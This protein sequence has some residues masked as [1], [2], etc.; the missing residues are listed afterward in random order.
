MNERRQVTALFRAFLGRFFENEMSE[1]S[2]DVRASFV[3]MIGMLAAPG[4]LLPFSN[5]YRW[6]GLAAQ[7]GETLRIATIADRLI[8]VSLA[9]AAMMLLAAVVWQALLVDRR[10]AIVLGSFPVRPRTI[11]AGKLLALL[12]Y[13]GIVTVGMNVIA[14][15]AYGLVLGGGPLGMLRAISGHFIASVLACMFACLSVAAFQAAVLAIAGPRVFVRVTASAQLVLA[16][17]ALLVF[18]MCPMIG[19]AAVD[20]A[21]GN[22][23]SA[24]V[25]WMPPMWFVGLYEVIIGSAR[26]IM[27]PMA[28]RALL[29]FGA[30]VAI[31]VAA[32]PLAYRRIAA[33]AM[34]GRPLGSRQSVASVALGWLMRR[35]PVRNDVRGAVHYTLLTTGR[36]ARNKLIIATAL[37]GAV[38]ISLPFILRWASAASAPS[39]PGRSQIAVPFLFLMLGL[40]GMRMAYN[41]PSEL[42]A[43][44]IFS[45]AVR[46]ARIG[47]SASRAAGLLIC[48][49]F[50][51]L[52]CLPLYLWFWPPAIAVSLSFT[53]FAF[54]AVI[55]ELALRSVDFVPYARAYNPERGKLQSRWPLFL[56]GFVLSMQALPSVVRFSLVA[57]NYVIMPLLLGLLAIG[58]RL[59]HPPEPPPLVDADFENKPLAL[60][61]Y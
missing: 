31:L 33:A 49:G 46:P 15:L 22:D 53:V 28:G 6:G 27:A 11:V 47:T 30:V 59:S 14:S 38:A 10:D 48:G 52:L 36:V 3:R 43:S 60:R 4:F 12:G 17:L 45:T 5:L 50:S 24:W 56:V 42:A 57:E 44:W 51:V 58:L 19:A 29:M 25:L 23:R 1:G 41:V 40:A 2:R 18:L 37:G 13:L 39:V 55:L 9:M 26:P 32:Y 54:G 61:L 7:G 35:L 8:Y 16:S 21:R 20:V 34:R